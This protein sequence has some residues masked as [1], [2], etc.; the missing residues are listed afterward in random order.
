MHPVA[1]SAVAHA[2]LA[3]CAAV[4]ASGA[5]AGERPLWEIGLGAAGLYLP[6]YR[7]SNQSRGYLYPLP[8][9]RYRGDRLK[10]DDRRG[11]AS[12]LLLDTDRIELDVSLN[13]SQPA[14][15]NHSDAR[16]GMPDLD[17]TLEIGPLVKV[18]L[19]ES[20]D[21]LR[22]L[23]LQLP[24]RAAFTLPS[25]EFIGWVFNP[26]IDLYLR[27]VGPGG[28]WRLGM[29]AGPVFNDRR[30]NEYYY[31]VDPQFATPTRPAYSAS[32]G[33]G[34]TQFTITTHRRF[35][36]VWVGAFMRAYALGGA[37][38]DNSPLVEQRSA[39]YAGIG[40]AYIFAESKT[41]VEADD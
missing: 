12:L 14:P 37:V 33:Y 17:A 27:D 38:F 21:R 15:S 41:L 32:G 4:S 39:F 19:W 35:G 8:Y 25:P 2:V 40:F 6:D 16:Q 36:P 23:S 20:G 9:V 7:G 31:Q 11:L 28:Q 10:L 3:L 26:V 13:A 30:Y 29:Q 5:R 18:K 1:T 24:V 34:G 22:E